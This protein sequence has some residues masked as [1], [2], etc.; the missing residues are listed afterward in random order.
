MRVADALDD[1][2]QVRGLVLLADAVLV[3][4]EGLG[5]EESA[6]DLGHDVFILE[7]I[8]DGALAAVVA[9]VGGGGV[10]GVDGEELALDEGGEVADPVDALDAGDAYVL[11]GGL[12]DDPL[13]ELLQCDVKPG[14]GILRGDDS[15]NG[16]VGE[17]GTFA[18]GGDALRLGVLGVLDVLGEGIRGA[19]CVLAGDDVEGGEAGVAGVDALCDDGGDE[20]EDVGADGAGDYVCLGDLLD[21]VLLV[22][23]GVDG[24]VVGDFVVGGAFGTDLD[25]L[26]GWGGVDLVDE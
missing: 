11:K 14:V 23:L 18:V 2:L 13:K 24:A 6:A 26:V 19:N 15:V 5:L 21:Q 7:G 9:V 20:A 22:G 3:D 8:V 25:D 12:V 16:R 17:A 1:L 4:D 10:A